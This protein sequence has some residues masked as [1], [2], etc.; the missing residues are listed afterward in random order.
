L[1]FH[2]VSP[3]CMYLPLQPSP[4]LKGYKLYWSKGYLPPSFCI[5]SFLLL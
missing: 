1:Y 3:L 5:I 2:M 4:L